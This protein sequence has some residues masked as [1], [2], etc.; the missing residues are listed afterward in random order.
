MGRNLTNLAVSESFQYLLQ[1]SGSNVQDGLG[2]DLTGSLLITA[3]LANTATSASFAQTASYVASVVSASYA[4]SSSFSNN[5]TSASYAATALSSSFAINATSASYAT[6][7]SQ[8]ITAS[9]ALNAGATVSTASLLTTAS[10]TNNVIT[11]TK[12]DSSTFNVTVATGSA[13]NTGSFMTTGSANANILTFTKGD[14]STF[15]LTVA[16]GSAVSASFA[17]TASLALNNV[18]T[19]SSTNATITY[20]KGDGTTFNNVINNVV[21]ADSASLAANATTASFAQNIANGL[22]PTF[23]NVTASNVLITGT[24]SVNLL[25]TT[26]IS[27]SVIF[28]SG[29]NLLGD[30]STL[31]TQT[32]IG[33]VKV[34]GSFSSTGSAGFTGGDFKV[35]DQNHNG[36]FDVDLFKVQTQTGAE[37]TGSVRS[38]NG[39]TGSLQGTASFATNATSASFASTSTS[40][41]FADNA[42]SASFAT[43]ASQAVTASFALNATPTNTGSLLTTASAVNNVITFTKGDAST[44]NVTVATGSA[45][46]SPIV[47]GSGLNSLVQTQYPLGVAYGSGSVVLGGSGLTFNTGSNPQ[48]ENGAVVI[49]GVSNILNSQYFGVDGA[50]LLGGNNNFIVS[51]KGNTVI[52]GEQNYADFPWTAVISGYQNGIDAG[53]KS[54]IFAGEHGRIRSNQSVIIGGY[55]GNIYSYNRACNIIGAG[56]S[57]NLYG[58]QASAILAGESN[59]IYD[60]AGDNG[61]TYW[62]VIVGGIGNYIA[63][64]TL[65][66][67]IIASSGS[68]LSGSAGN[69]TGSVILGGSRITGSANNT[70]YVPNLVTTGSATINGPVTISNGDTLAEALFVVGN[71]ALGATGNTFNAGARYAAIIGN[72]NTVS[73]QGDFSVGERNAIK[74]GAYSVILGGTDNEVETNSS[75]YDAI[76]ASYDCTVHNLSNPSPYEA[77][78]IGSDTSTANGNKVSIISSTT[79]NV[80]SNNSTTIAGK[81][82][83]I[84]GSTN[85]AIIASTGSTAN[86]IV[87][88][89]VIGGQGIVATADNTVY[90]PNLNLSGSITGSGANN[91]VQNSTDIYTSSAAVRQIV[92]CTQ[93]EYN[94]IGSPDANTLYVISGSAPFNS[95]A[96]ATTGSNTFSGSQVITGSLRG[97]VNA[98]TISSQTASLDLS[99]SNFFTLSLVSGSTTYLNPSNINPGQT[100]NIKIQQPAVSFGSIA[101]PSIVKQASGSAYTPTISANAIDIITLISF[102]STDLYLSN[103]KNLITPA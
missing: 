74:A 55:Y 18:L 21:N 23:T 12:G 94:S 51:G 14:G 10:A 62:S 15:N 101:F 35:T 78:I 43:S 70:V 92:T 93:A 6:S 66:S 88:S 39:F 38:L 49:G 20:T 83:T 75:G 96:F 16:T 98:L 29:S 67:G 34:S 53:F 87:N 102:D 41:S 72:A 85:T 9:Y 76:I 8:A 45:V 59:Q 56:I 40:A 24:A 28:S 84:S 61:N 32:L 26:T 71:T 11:F 2:N 82:N 65:Y 99:T 90:V 46:S 27:S 7:A 25:H 52:G 13:I 80:N 22:S 60:A 36:E 64:N 30:S 73:G 31:D 57:N 42:T 77:V 1:Y 37:F 81:V 48:S 19:A 44:F 58:T 54:G 50:V 3:S 86:S 95:S 69:M 97:S 5:S 4:V 33:V 89:A 47:S 91:L 103:V 100:V 17:T 79:S 63:S 68:L